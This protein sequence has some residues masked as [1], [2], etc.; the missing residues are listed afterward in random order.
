MN[1]KKLAILNSSAGLISQVVTILFQFIARSVFIKYL[2]VELLGLNSTFA[3]ILNALALAELGFQSAIIYSLYKPIKEENH[4]EINKIVSVFC[5]VY[6]AIGIF[7]IVVSFALLPFLQ[8]ILKGVVVDTTIYVFFLLQAASSAFTYF[9]AYKRTILNADQKGYI[10]K[11]IDLVINVISNL[12][13]IYVMI[14]LH[15]YSLY[16]IIRILQVVI[17]NILVH[18]ACKKLYPYLKLTKMDMSVFSRIW[19]DVK[20]VFVAKIAGYIYDSTDNLVISVVINTVTVGFFTNYKTITKSLKILTT[21]MLAPITPII[22]RLLVDDG[23]NEEKEKTFLMYNHIRYIISLFLVVPCFTLIDNCISIWVGSEFIMSSGVSFLLCLDLFIH[24][25][26]GGCCDYINGAGL[27]RQEKQI[28][29]V[30]AIIN[31]VLSVALCTQFGVVGILIGTVLA[32]FWFWVGRS[33]VVYKYC[34]DMGSKE[35]IRYILECLEYILVTAVAV[36]CSTFAYG[37]LTIDNLVLK[38]IT[39]GLISIF[40]CA[41][42]YIICYGWRSEFRAMLR[43]IKRKS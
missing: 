3:S 28:E 34:F 8:F 11:L 25:V 29:I 41:V 35:Y 14:T 38:F 21:S 23:A 16:L 20:N 36:L 13:Q 19:V 6:R 27:F 17:S 40:I 1:I 33:Y 5:Y 22:G 24:L 26:H 4:D 37:M 2:G 15:S 31:L 7:F 12:L 42:I 18:V 10:A 39:G 9:L 32:Q 30:G 43:I